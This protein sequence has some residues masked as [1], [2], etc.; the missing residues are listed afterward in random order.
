MSENLSD[1]STAINSD[2]NLT[3]GSNN[4]ANTSAGNNIA[5]GSNNTANA[6]ADNNVTEGSNN[7]ANTSADNNIADSSNNTANASA[8]N[9]IA[10]GSNNT[11]ST[12][13]AGVN[14]ESAT[15]DKAPIKKEPK[16]KF[17]TVDIIMLPVVFILAFLCTKYYNLNT[18][19]ANLGLG[20]TVYIVLYVISVLVY[21][22]LKAV[23]FNSESIILSVL[24]ILL[25]I[26]FTV[27]YNY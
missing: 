11:A 4:T 2:N 21:A 10:D 13:T 8:G 1:N 9:N 22:K 3:E 19:V 17:E 7:T 12:S 14:T 27:F 24:M 15:S 6:S 25:A 23:K 16:Y 26:S 5:D 18:G 20:A